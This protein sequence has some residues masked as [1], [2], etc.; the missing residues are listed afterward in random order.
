M[1]ADNIASYPLE[2]GY[3]ATDINDIT[4]TVLSFHAN[5]CHE[6]Q[7][8]LCIVN[9]TIVYIMLPN[10]QTHAIGIHVEGTM[11]R[12]DIVHYSIM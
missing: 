7:N 4:I 11:Q 10:L 9:S 5:N 12:Y 2:P 3:E 1:V 6:S 8:H